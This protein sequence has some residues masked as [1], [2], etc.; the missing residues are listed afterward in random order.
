[1][2]DLIKRAVE[3][4][5]GWELVGEVVYPPFRH[6]SVAMHTYNPSTPIMDALAAQLV[7]QVDARDCCNIIVDY[8]Y[9]RLY[10]AETLSDVQGTGPDRTMNTIKAIVESDVLEKIDE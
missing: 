2:S 7:R 9:A 5:D 8:G 1:M 3:L 4:A 6:R 10:D